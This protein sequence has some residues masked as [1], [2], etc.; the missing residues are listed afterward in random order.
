MISNSLYNSHNFNILSLN[1]RSLSSINKFNSFRNILFELDDLPK[2]ISIQETWFNK[3]LVQLFNI[4]NFS[5]VH[6][7]RDDSYGGVS[8]YIHKSLKFDV[9]ENINSNF[10]NIINIALPDILF[11]GKILNLVSYYRS[12]KCSLDSFFNLIES[13]LFRIFN[14]PCLV[15]GDT[16]IDLCVEDYRKSLLLDFFSFFSFDSRHD[17]ITR[18]ISN[19][20]IDHVFCNDLNLMTNI[21]SLGNDL[22]DHN[23]IMILINKHV[24]IDKTVVLNIRK[25]NFLRVAYTINSHFSNFQ[26]DLADPNEFCNGIVDSVKNIIED[27]TTSFDLKKSYKGQVAPWI[28]DSL[29][30]LLK[31][32]KRL[33]K[34]SKKFPN[35]LKIMGDF[36]RIN[37]VVKL[38]VNNSKE[39]YYQ[40]RVYEC[41]NDQ[42]KI[43][44]FLN[45]VSGRSVKVSTDYLLKNQSRISDPFMVAEEFNDFFVSVGASISSSIPASPSDNLNFFNTL[46]Y[47]FPSFQFNTCGECEFVDIIMHL[48]NT[49]S[50]GFDCI[51][52]KVL[53][54]SVLAF[55]KIF[56]A[57]FN[58]IIYYSIY[59]D[60]FKLQIVVPILKNGDNFVTEN[61]RPISIPS[62]C[63]K[64]IEKV[65]FIQLESFLSAN[66]FFYPYQYGFRKGIGTHNALI[67]VVDMVCEN[68]TRFKMVTGVFID[69]KKAFDTISHD[70]LLIKLRLIGL[71]DSSLQL[72]RSYLSGRKQFVK[73]K[74]SLSYERD[75]NIGVPQGSILGPL[76]FLIFI[77]DIHKLPLIGKLFLFADDCSLF[78]PDNDV[79]SVQRKVLHD[80]RLLSEFFRL[81]KICMN[82]LKTKIINF[83]SRNMAFDLIKLD[84]NGSLIEEVK[85]LKFLG[86]VFD[87][88]LTWHAH[89]DNISSKLSSFN[90]LMFKF[91]NK[92]SL[93]IKMQMYYAFAHSHLTYG[94]AL[95]GLSSHIHRIQV[96]QNKILKNILNLPILFNTLRLYEISNVMPVKGVC[97]FQLMLGIYKILHNIGHINISSVER[98]NHRFE[99]RNRNDIRILNNVNVLTS[100]RISVAGSS[101]FNNLPSC[102]KSIGNLRSF[103]IELNRLLLSSSYLETII[104]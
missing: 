100:Q 44:G 101:L 92:F 77:N 8:I 68:L 74:D 85:E 32:K 73:F 69:L 94:V 58:K 30:N 15:F 22:S 24:S 23:I 80:L 17:L 54:N 57:L 76:L 67:D 36:E 12:P 84:F 103:K 38:S 62:V 48:R 13:I 34:L 89:I 78:Y 95:W 83:K 81:N 6:S 25:T 88:H 82:A 99:T 21:E 90:G 16:N 75:V 56:S 64:P 79:L 28:N 14:L 26:C 45:K 47:N 31:E 27:N 51:P 63:S 18:P 59:P 66:N 61:Y 40:R 104:Y 97:H 86:L 35:S 41:G 20:C 93:K 10:C 11:D 29:L 72:I 39:G 96:L 46:N 102:V 3:D 87:S 60:A 70:L 49:N 19:S 5:A 7:C 91:K 65:L 42:R 50:V 53:K 33:L 52:T 2:V 55:S 9:I 1:A 37:K 43:W 4:D 98:F 71:C